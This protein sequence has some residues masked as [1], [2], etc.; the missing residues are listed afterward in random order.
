MIY[1]FSVVGALLD[2]VVRDRRVAAVRQIDRIA[3][4]AVEIENA[5][6]GDGVVLRPALDLMAHGGV[7]NIAVGEA[8]LG[9]GADIEAVGEA[10]AI[11]VEGDLRIVD[12]DRAIRIGRAKQALLVVVEVVVAE[13][14][15]R[16]PRSGSPR[17]CHRPP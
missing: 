6:I 8:E 13:A 17:H 12:R 10:G 14:S 9:D 11:T 16:R 1:G 4:A 2:H 7:V 5:V 3:G 15:G